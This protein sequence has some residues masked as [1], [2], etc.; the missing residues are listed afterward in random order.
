MPQ[1]SASDA[2]WQSAQRQFQAGNF[3]AARVEAERVL[4]LEPWHSGAHLLLSNLS[5]AQERHRD[6]IQQ[7]LLAAQRMGRQSLQ[8]VAAVALKLIS[9]GEYEA[10]ATL[11]RKIDPERVPAPGSLAEF[12]QQLSLLE[13]HQDALRYLDAALGLGLDGDWVHYVHG[14]YLKFLGRMDEALVAYEHSLALSPNQALAHYAIATT[15]GREGAGARIDRLRRSIDH[16]G[17]GFRELAYLYYA[18]FRELD[19]GEDTAAAWA[20]LEA[21]FNDR[22]ARVSYDAAEESAV[23]DEVIA[24]TPA[25]FAQGG[26]PD[27]GGPVPVFILGL[28]RTGTT[29]LERVLGGNPGI[30][31]CGE[32]NDFRMQYKWASDHFCLGFFDRRAAQLLGSVDHAELG[33]RYQQHVAW[34]IPAASSHFTDKNPGNFMMAG[35]ILRALPQARI[36]HLRRNPMDACFSNLK[37]LFGANAH[38]YSYGFADLASH[39]GNYM[40]LMA[41]WH[42]I[43]PGRI[44]DVHYEELVSDPEASTRRVMA[45]LGLPYDAQ[46]IRVESHAAPVSTASSAQVRQPIH[47]RNVGGWMRYAAQLGPLRELLEGSRG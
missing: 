24:R 31:L 44:L 42:E 41:H 26:A 12:S 3:P 21:G 10:A 7:A 27:P 11:V 23:F 28:P 20:A 30:A 47:R 5:S 8:H 14:N 22:R 40:R 19:S 39:H 34:R 18:L 45:Y 9:V 4:V 15:A 32:L 33:R 13:Q 43:A 2:P 17:P 46:Q 35:P 16:V 37:E 1:P 36:L 25:G 29:L 6:A 38:P